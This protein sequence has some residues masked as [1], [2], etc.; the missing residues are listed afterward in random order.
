MMIQ[1]NEGGENM[2][3]EQQTPPA[4]RHGMSDFLKALLWTVVP[5]IVLSAVASGGMMAGAA[6]GGFNAIG[7]SAP[8]LWGVAILTAIGFMIARKRQIAAGIWAG[9]GISI[10]G[11]GVTC[12]AAVIS[13]I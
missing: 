2:E 11:L 1:K 10:I 7:I 9:V 4:P 3:Q 8:V 6:W 5:I 12:F 13:S